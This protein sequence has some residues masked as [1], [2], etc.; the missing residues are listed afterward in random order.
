MEKENKRVL[1]I[2]YGLKRIGIAVSDPLNIFAIALTTLDN[3][4]KLE[5]ELKKI[6]DEYEIG[7]VVLGYPLKEDGS[8][9][10]STEA[11]LQ[12]KVT[13]EKKFPFEVKLRD[14]RFTSSIA[15]ERIKESVTSK[16]SRR[17]K[18]LI[19]KN[20]AAVLL[21]DYLSEIN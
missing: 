1:A 15:Y 20:A 4:P 9:T 17:N 18:K 11:V 16:K 19:D 10:H 6:I 5:E 3:A 14:E 2:D 13:F 21:E 8:F 7:E 12:F